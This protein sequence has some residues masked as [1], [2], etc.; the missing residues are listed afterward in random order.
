MAPRKEQQ[1]FQ[2][3]L[4]LLAAKGYEGL[5][6]EGVAERSGVNKTTIYR[7]W[8]S[9]AALLAA[10]LVE[11]DLLVSAPPDTGSLRG[12]LE[13]LLRGVAAL[14]TSPPAADVAVAALGAAVHHP[15][16]ATAAQRFFADR[17]A[18]EEAVFAR[19]R[20][21]GEL[22][23]TADPMLIM[24][25]LAGAVWLRAVFRGLPLDDDFAAGAVAAVLDGVTRP[26]AADAAKSLG[27]VP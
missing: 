2:A 17:F 18:R 25:L 4:E 8:P 19:A 7:W 5:T 6:V 24:D 9:K 20:R 1:I 12:D 27:E 14:L 16:L 21:R 15:E 22:P 13:A 11:A 10:A 23:D 26:K 3:T